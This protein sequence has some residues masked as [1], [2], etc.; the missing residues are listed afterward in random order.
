[1]TLSSLFIYCPQASTV[2][3]NITTSTRPV[4]SSIIPVFKNFEGSFLVAFWTTW[5]KSPQTVTLLSFSGF[6]KISLTVSVVMYFRVSL[7]DESGCEV[8]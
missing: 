2:F 6:S 7:I 4:K 8:T 1:M 3:G 5:D